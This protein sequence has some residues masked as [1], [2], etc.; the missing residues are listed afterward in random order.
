MQLLTHIDP[1]KEPLIR[2]E[3]V[4]PGTHITAIGSDTPD[5]IELDPMLLHHAE[6]VVC[7]SKVQATQRGEVFQAIKK[8]VLSIESVE[9]IGSILARSEPFHRNKNAISVCDL[10]GIGALDLAIAETVLEDELQS[11]RK[12]KW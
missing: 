11:M 2:Y 5:K 3:W 8:G 6:Y 12:N 1:T 9:E 10:T 7:D 4:R